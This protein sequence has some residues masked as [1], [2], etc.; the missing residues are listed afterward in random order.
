MSEHPQPTPSIAAYAILADLRTAPLLANGSVDWLCLPRFDSP[1]VFSRLI[2]DP[3]GSRWLIAPRGGTVTSRAYREMSFVLDTQW[4]A[5]DGTAVSTDFMPISGHRADVIRRIRCTGGRIDVDVDLVLRFDYGAVRPWV[6]QVSGADGRPVMRAIAGPDSIALHGPRL[7]GGNHRHHGSFTLHE[8]ESLTWT[9]TWQPSYLE[10]PAAPDVEAHL[11]DTLANWRQW[12]QGVS[13]TGPYA[14]PV[15]R[16]L[17]VLRALTVRESGGVVAAATT[18]LPESI[19]GERNWDYRFCWLRDSALTIE[20]LVAHGHPHLAAH[21][22]DWLLRAVAG[23]PED[24]QIMYGPAGERHLDERELSHLDGFRGSAP[25]RVGNGAVTQYQAD[26]VGEVMLSLAALRAAGVEEGDYSWA[27]QLNLLQ[28]AEQQLDVPDNGIWEMRGQPR[29]FT[30]G[31]VMMWAAFDCGIRAV[32]EHG[33]HGPVEKWER[34]REQLRAE[35]ER[36]GFDPD[37][38]SFRQ[39]YDTDAVDASLLQL[40]HTGFIAADDPKMLGTVAR[41]ER[42]LVD[43]HG[44]VRR[45][46]PDGG[47]GMSGGE[48]SFVMCSFWLV[49]QYAASGRLDEARALMDKLV[50]LRNDVGLL[51][52]EYDADTGEHLGNTPQAFSHLALIRAADAIAAHDTP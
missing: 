14:E 44:F 32:R 43:D 16:S 28:R 27:L 17:A 18:S 6:H 52:E 42:D 31:R 2:G 45:Y 22:R 4:A 21:W 39:H 19:G 29:F 38:G 1:A 46:L 33:R 47:D 41:I 25:V 3:Q 24:L 8:G 10:L 20:A 34:I 36:R 15:A 5:P 50:G 40:P 9:M 13:A 26:V 11:T 12:Q 7:T 49:T 48:G 51:S 30:H 35:I 23:D 37:S